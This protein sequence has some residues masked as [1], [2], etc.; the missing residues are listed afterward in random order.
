[1]HSPQASYELNDY[2]LGMNSYLSNDKFPLN[3]G[4][5]NLWRLAQ[6]ARIPTLGEYET[7]KGFDYYSHP[8]TE[9]GVS[10]NTATG[11]SHQPLGETVWLAQ[12]FVAGS[13]GRLT[14]L[15]PKLRNTLSGIGTVSVELWTDSSGAPG[16]LIARSSIDSTVITTSVT[17]AS[18]DAHFAASPDIVSGTT[19]WIVCHIQLY[20]G[21][22]YEWSS[23]TAATSAK[24]SANSGV[25]W[26]ST[27]FALNYIVYISTA[28]P[29]IGL[30]RAYKSD[31]TKVTLIAYNTALIK[32]DD[33][34]GNPTNVKTGL[35][36]SA[37]TA[38]FATFNDVVYY[39]NNYDGL[40]KWDFTTESQVNATNYSLICNHKGLL[41][42]AGGADP[43]AVVF[44]NFGL[45]ETYTSTDFVYADVPK[46]GDP[47][48][49]LVSLNGNL[50]IFSKANK[51]V[52]SGDNDDNFRVDEAP[53]QKGTYTQETVCQDNNSMYFLSDDGVYR[54]NGSEAHLMSA[55]IYEEI[56]AIPDK[57]KCV[58]AVNRGRLYLWFPSVGS[59]YN[60]SCY[61]WN[62]NL[63]SDGKD[64]VESLDTDAFVTRAFSSANDND[65]LI[66]GSSRV[67]QA[68]W[69]ELD[70]NDYNNIGG[71][72]NF[73]LRTN[74]MTFGHPAQLHAL[75]YWS[76]R[77]AASS[78]NNTVDCS[79][80]YDL[81]PNATL[82]TSQDVQGSGYQWGDGTLWGSGATWGTNAEVQASLYVPGEYRR[83]QLRYSHSG[84]R[85]YV[86]FLGHS[87]TVQQRRLR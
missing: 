79:Y 62:L 37:T 24:S 82:V 6:D 59:G 17:S 74:Y 75:R 34:T 14:R 78:S 47:V 29:A 77:F 57:T 40:R 67:A 42:L 86:R 83:V 46:N 21:G 56:K 54:S 9:S 85:Q 12:S 71:D 11:A 69:Q 73:E 3:N 43:N 68:W 49:A 8:A 15:A 39:V 18:Y 44:S 1:M 63:R 30:Y 41:F 28:L 51:F 23:T 7:R 87:L 64:C 4:G 72:I 66:V 22:S 81:N 70:S 58:L 65:A 36:G 26:S 31:G 13:T 2:S 45:A 10:F 32:I 38:R 33:V 55:P 20:G 27:S 76:P 80:A 16:S 53:D 48:T 35:S 61:V 50:F 19:Y 60:D 52:L 25:T 84:A 5:A